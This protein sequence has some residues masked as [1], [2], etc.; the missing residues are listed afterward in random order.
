VGAEPLGYAYYYC[1]TSDWT[2]LACAGAGVTDHRPAH[3]NAPIRRRWVL[4]RGSR[5]ASRVLPTFYR[6]RDQN[7]APPDLGAVV[8]GAVEGVDADA[9]VPAVDVGEFWV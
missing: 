8:G 7:P 3:N 6:R 9:G 1:D 4:T 2:V 5:T